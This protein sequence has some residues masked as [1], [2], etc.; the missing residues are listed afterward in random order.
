MKQLA[1]YIGI[2]NASHRHLKVHDGLQAW[3]QQ[4]AEEE[5]MMRYSQYDFF[6]ADQAMGY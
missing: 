2:G 3:W 6:T 5:E 1:R 4:F